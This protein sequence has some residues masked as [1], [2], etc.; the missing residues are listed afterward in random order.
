MDV[1]TLVTSPNLL[2][3]TPKVRVNTTCMLLIFQNTKTS[4]HNVYS[5]ST[6]THTFTLN[7]TGISHTITV[8]FFHTPQEK[9][10][11]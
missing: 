11:E 7:A 10:P 2:D 9:L 4:I 5:R 1:Q 6:D 3:I 8:L